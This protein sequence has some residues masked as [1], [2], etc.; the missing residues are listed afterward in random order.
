MNRE[1]IIWGKIKA[2]AQRL[3]K[4]EGNY[5]GSIEANVKKR[6]KQSSKKVIDGL[7]PPK[8]MGTRKSEKVKK[9]VVL[10]REGVR[11]G[12]RRARS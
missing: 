11:N 7:N 3:E 9:M 8:G 1:G 10:K 5:E 12:K 6:L 2:T 4:R